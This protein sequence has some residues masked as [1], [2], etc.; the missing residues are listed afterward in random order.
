MFL[1][2]SRISVN[3][4]ES[5]LQCPAIKI[6][7]NR[8][9]YIKDEEGCSD[10]DRHAAESLVDVLNS[11]VLPNLTSAS[12]LDG[13]YPIGRKG[14]DMHGFCWDTSIP[15]RD[16]DL[17][18]RT[19]LIPDV[20]YHDPRSH[21]EWLD[22][23]DEQRFC[24]IFNVRSV[25]FQPSNCPMQLAESPCFNDPNG[26]DLFPFKFCFSSKE[27][28]ASYNS[29]V[30]NVICNTLLQ[31]KCRS[32]PLRLAPKDRRFARVQRVD[33]G[34]AVSFDDATKCDESRDLGDLGDLGDAMMRIVLSNCGELLGIFDGGR[35]VDFEG[36]YLTHDTF[37][38]P[39]IDIERDVAHVSCGD[40]RGWMEALRWPPKLI[41]SADPCSYWFS[42]VLRESF[43]H[44][45]DPTYNFLDRADPDRI[46]HIRWNAAMASA[47]LTRE[48][49]IAYMSSVLQKIDQ[50]GREFRVS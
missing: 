14:R 1:P 35:K 23:Y 43:T 34:H 42:L 6:K 48:K 32:A 24:S 26:L 16:I 17:E 4:L 30:R 18:D 13:Y 25:H 9:S 8:A 40:Y 12:N 44:V 50:F 29:N 49:A 7:N 15:T 33:D 5:S 22:Y 47:F 21:L 38:F 3:E 19:L 10:D 27:C 39:K 46:D 28:L 2:Y 45:Y 37:L 11:D 41:V 36:H 20:R 31:L